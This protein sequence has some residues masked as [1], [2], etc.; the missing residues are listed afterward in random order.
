MKN[1][2]KVKEAEIMM[3]R[4]KLMTTVGLVNTSCSLFKNFS[5]ISEQLKCAEILLKLVM[6]SCI[7]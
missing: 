7:P 2:I 4:A 3:V 1:R 6:N 5:C